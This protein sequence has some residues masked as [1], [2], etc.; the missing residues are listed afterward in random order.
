MMLRFV[1][2][3]IENIIYLFP[4]VRSE[5][6]EFT[7]NPMKGRLKKVPLSRIL[8]IEQLQKL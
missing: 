2:K 6:Q 7:V 3:S 8:R 1:Y 4:N 5:T